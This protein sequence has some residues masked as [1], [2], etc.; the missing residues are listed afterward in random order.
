MQV[1][2]NEQS[3]R[4]NGHKYRNFYTIFEEVL[5]NSEFIK[6]QYRAFTFLFEKEAE[7][8]ENK[9][10]SIHGKH[11]RLDLFNML[12]L[13]LLVF[14]ENIKMA[15]GIILDDFFQNLSA[16]MNAKCLS[17]IRFKKESLPDDHKNLLFSEEIHTMSNLES[18][19]FSN[20]NSVRNPVHA[21]GLNDSIKVFESGLRSSKPKSEKGILSQTKGG[22]TRRKEAENVSKFHPERQRILSFKNIERGLKFSGN[23]EEATKGHEQSANAKSTE[24]SRKVTPPADAPAKKDR[25]QDVSSHIKEES[26]SIKISESSSSKRS[27]EPSGINFHI[28]A[29][30][31]SPQAPEGVPQVH[32]APEKKTTATQPKMAKQAFKFFNKKFGL[33]QKK[34]SR[35]KLKKSLKSSS[36]LTPFEFKFDKK[37]KSH[38]LRG[39]FN[40]RSIPLS[41]NFNLS[42]EKSLEGVTLYKP[43]KVK[44][45]K[46]GRKKGDAFKKPT[47]KNWIESNIRGKE[48]FF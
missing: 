33:S 26:R 3:L 44:K 29:L 25:M 41:R 14:K 4:E 9:L 18:F 30:N 16:Q 15:L 7:F 35:T 48:Q 24:K 22:L 27:R 21:T 32:T 10:N 12:M 39:N 23:T 34:K 8:I 28:F 40:T 46:K 6:R 11:S 38:N 19:K 36:K 1:L 20:Q 42:L 5:N 17:E 2:P 43:G 47:S 37:T 31:D 13:N 45:G